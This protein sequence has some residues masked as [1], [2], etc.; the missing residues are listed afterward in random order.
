MADSKLSEQ[1][2]A[3]R[4]GASP[5]MQRINAIRTA[6]EV[7]DKAGRKWAHGKNK[8]TGMI[9]FTATELADLMDEIDAGKRDRRGYVVG[10]DLDAS[11]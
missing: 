6:V 4:V 5:W 8:T 10:A 9:L 2:E 7:H 3:V 11:P 1:L